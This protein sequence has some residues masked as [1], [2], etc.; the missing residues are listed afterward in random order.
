MKKKYTIK[1]LEE[2]SDSA[3]LEELALS[4]WVASETVQADI[5]R[6][7][8]GL[9][10]LVLDLTHTVVTGVRSKNAE[11]R[12]YASDVRLLIEDTKSHFSERQREKNE[13]RTIRWVIEALNQGKASIE[14]GLDV[15]SVSARLQNL[16]HGHPR[17]Q[18]NTSV[19]DWTW[20]LNHWKG[21]VKRRRG[22]PVIGERSWFE[23]VYGI[24]NPGKRQRLKAAVAMSSEFERAQKKLRKK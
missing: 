9:A 19:G 2:R 7:G 8:L 23:V 11:E 24:L 1:P 22:N 14:D 21:Y 10:A 12:A 5:A 15:N 16:A 17:Y 18:L 20:A 6:I 4:C 13:I 3:V